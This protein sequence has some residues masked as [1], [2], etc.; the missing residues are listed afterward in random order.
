[1]KQV[2]FIYIDLNLKFAS[3]G[4]KIR[5]AHNNLY[6]YTLDL[7]IKV[8]CRGK[9]KTKKHYLGKG[10]SDLSACTEWIEM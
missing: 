4:F 6:P 3:E 1:M 10:E 2:K 5:A 8:L 9:K 7:D